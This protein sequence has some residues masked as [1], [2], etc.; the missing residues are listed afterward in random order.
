M[1]RVDPGFGPLLDREL[2]V[3]VQRRRTAVVQL[4]TLVV[5]SGAALIGAGMR[6]VFGE[7][8]KQPQDPFGRDVVVFSL[9]ALCV[10]LGFIAPAL[11]ATGI[12]EERERRTLDLLLCTRLTPKDIILGKLWSGFIQGTLIV[13]ASA[14]AVAF[15][16]WWGGVA[17]WHVLVAYVLVLLLLLLL[18]AMGLF[19]SSR[20]Q[21]TRAAVGAAYGIGMMVM[22]PVGT[23]ALLGLAFTYVQGRLDGTLAAILG[24]VLLVCAWISSACV[25]GAIT[26]VSPVSRDPAPAARKNLVFIVGTALL[27]ALA[28]GFLQDQQLKELLCGVLLAAVGLALL[29]TSLLFVTEDP[30]ARVDADIPVVLRANP[31]TGLGWLLGAS[32][33]GAGLVPA[34]A[35]RGV[36]APFVTP[37]TAAAFV[38]FFA[39]CAGAA[40]LLRLFNIRRAG[41]RILA[42]GM[43]MVLLAGPPLLAFL[44]GHWRLELAPSWMLLWL[45]PVALVMGTRPGASEAVL[46]PFGSPMI[47]AFCVGHIMLAVGT[48]LLGLV[49]GKKAPRLE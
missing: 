32:L 34:L 16:T 31:L 13:L 36:P 44:T 15:G 43:L 45:H 20:A 17:I 22:L 19:S 47:V 3:A 37:A 11:T 35:L 2:T 10:M 7:S 26:S 24:M 6:S 1:M 29:V 48:L 25:L 12:T 5:T 41:R 46:G 49:A 4:L 23:P 39:S 9:V 30:P 38:P 21:A 40:A 28:V 14:P 27:G 8:Y 18:L 33:L 42:L